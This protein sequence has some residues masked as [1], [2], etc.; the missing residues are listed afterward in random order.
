MKRLVLAGMFVTLV[1]TGAALAQ[2]GESAQGGHTAPKPQPATGPAVTAPEGAIALGT[3]SIGRR[4]KA[5]GKDLAAGTYQVRLTADVA[6]PEAKGATA[7][8][9]R[10]VEF[11]RG[12][13]VVAREVVSI[14]PQSE[15]GVVQKDTPPG[16]NSSK[17]ETLK[18]GDYVR[19]WIRRGGNHYLMH[20]PVSA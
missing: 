8:L 14:I 5:D 6:S 10:W 17:V 16:N 7:G 2:S 15:I 11:V 4:V 19:V 1:G 9:E 20:L 3:V 18:G 12:G 13:K